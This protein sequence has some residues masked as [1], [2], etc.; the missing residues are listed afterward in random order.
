M[1]YSWKQFLISKAGPITKETLDKL[2]DITLAEDK[3]EYNYHEN[4]ENIQTN[5]NNSNIIR[6]KHYSV[7]SPEYMA[8]NSK[9]EMPEKLIKKLKEKISE[10]NRTPR[11]KKMINENNVKIINPEYTQWVSNFLS[12]LS[13]PF[14]SAERIIQLNCLLLNNNI[15][16]SVFNDSYLKYGDRG[17]DWIGLYLDN[18]NNPKQQLQSYLRDYHFPLDLFINP[19][20]YI[21]DF[22]LER[23]IYALEEKRRYICV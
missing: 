1:K 21:Q 7:D 6:I 8:F 4:Q 20:I 18:L 5:I 22:V 3:Q 23:D 15:E 13:G 10:Q 2:F 11:P 12:W 16:F 9:Y 14:D 19:Q 17:F